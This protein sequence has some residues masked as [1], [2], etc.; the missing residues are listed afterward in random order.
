MDLLLAV[1]T[2]CVMPR[3]LLVDF[4]TPGVV[5]SLERLQMHS[6]PGVAVKAKEL[7]AA[8]VLYVRPSQL[9]WEAVTF[10]HISTF[11]NDLASRFVSPSLKTCRQP[12]LAG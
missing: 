5:R 3:R 12:H 10:T 1:L 9:V 6:N 7:V 2:Q 4:H 11:G 8:E